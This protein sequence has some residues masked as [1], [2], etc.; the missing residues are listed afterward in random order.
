MIVS[1]SSLKW[2]SSNHEVACTKANC[3]LQDWFLSYLISPKPEE[4]S[5]KHSSCDSF[6]KTGQTGSRLAF[7]RISVVWSLVNPNMATRRFFKPLRRHILLSTQ[8]QYH[9]TMYP[10]HMIKKIFTFVNLLFRDAFTLEDIED[11]RLLSF[12]FMNKLE[13][14]LSIHKVHKKITYLLKFLRYKLRPSNT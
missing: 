5:T 4:I 14:P 10:K 9:P 11:Q 13:G 12:L 1:S 6:F 3:V 7:F 2:I 8:T